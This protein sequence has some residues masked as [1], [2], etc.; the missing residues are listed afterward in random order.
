MRFLRSSHIFAARPCMVSIASMILSCARLLRRSSS[1]TGSSGSSVTVLPPFVLPSR[2]CDAPMRGSIAPLE[3]S[4]D[5]L[6]R[7]VAAQEQTI[8]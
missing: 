6:K 2:R 4:N 1:D 8:D 3:G 5:A 7:T